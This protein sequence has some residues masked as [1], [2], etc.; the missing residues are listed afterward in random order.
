MTNDSEPQIIEEQERVELERAYRR[1]FDY[2]PSF[3]GW[4]R[5]RQYGGLIA[6][7]GR[8]EIVESY[9]TYGAFEERV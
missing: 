1:L 3:P 7:P 9:T 5:L 4:A 2:E 8:L 6:Y